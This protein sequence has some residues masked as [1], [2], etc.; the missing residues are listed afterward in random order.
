[1]NKNLEIAQERFERTAFGYYYDNSKFYLI[2][3]IENNNWKSS[4]IFTCKEEISKNFLRT[5]QGGQVFLGISMGNKG[6]ATRDKQIE[7]IKAIQAWEEKLNV[8]QENRLQFVYKD[9]IFAIDVGWWGG[10]VLRFDLLMCRLKSS[11]NSMSKYI[12]KSSKYPLELFFKGKTMF[13]GGKKF[14]TVG[15]NNYY[16]REGWSSFFSKKTKE[17][18]DSLLKEP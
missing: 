5:H 13:S 10:D 7:K 11:S 8:P 16:G 14:Y 4:S 17:E 9:G 2:T 6:K 18:I 15:E 12:R 1:M 3:S